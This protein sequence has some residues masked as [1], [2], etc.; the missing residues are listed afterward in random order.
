[1]PGYYLPWREEQLEALRRGF[2]AIV[3]RIVERWRTKRYLYVRNLFTWAPTPFFNTGMVVDADRS[4]HPTNLG[5]SAGLEETLGETRVGS[6]DD[7]PSREVLEQKAGEVNA[8]LE[9]ALPPDV[10]RSTLAVDAELSRF[11]RALYGEFAAYRR[12]KSAA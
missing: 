5:L 12:R 9:R 4:I 10:W 1:M 8:L 6:L 7:P 2:D 3:A 11:C